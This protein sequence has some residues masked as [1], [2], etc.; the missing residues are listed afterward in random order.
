MLFRKGYLRRLLA[1]AL[2]LRVLKLQLPVARLHS[3]LPDKARLELA[4]RD[5]TYPHL[6]EIALCQCETRGSFLVDLLLRHKATLRRLSLSNMTLVGGRSTWRS[7]FT[8]VGG[9]L[10]RLCMVK[11][12]G[13]FDIENSLDTGIDLPRGDVYALPYPT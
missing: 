3:P 1:R 5:I 7:V 6:Y 12:R 13:S 4:L 11:F 10:P 9:Q 8:K 2:E